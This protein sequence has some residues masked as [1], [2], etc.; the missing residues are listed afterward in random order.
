[1]PCLTPDDAVH[2]CPGKPLVPRWSGVF[3][4]V[5]DVAGRW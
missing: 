5:V 4:Q 3:G 2:P 1:M